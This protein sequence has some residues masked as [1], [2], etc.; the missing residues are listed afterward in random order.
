[1]AAKEKGQK[2]HRMPVAGGTH[3]AS[4]F[5]KDVISA[6][7]LGFFGDCV[8]ATTMFL[9]PHRIFFW[10]LY[11]LVKNRQHMAH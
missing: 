7:I 9:L 1:M 11:I 4:H 6:I 10:A 5:L 2:T 8:S 3:R